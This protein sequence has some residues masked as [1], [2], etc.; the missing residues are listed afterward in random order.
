MNIIS[1]KYDFSAKELF[2][3]EMIRKYFISDVLDIPVEQIHSVRLSNTFLWKRYRRQKQG[4]LDV[5]VELNDDTKINIELQ[6][7]PYAHW[8]KRILFY[9]SK[10]FTEDL[11]VGDNYSR[12]NRCVS[13]SILDFNLKEGEKYNTIYRLRYEAHLKEI[14]GRNAREDYVREE[15]RKEGVGSM[16]RLTEILLNESR[17]DNLKRASTDKKYRQRLFEEYRIK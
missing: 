5:L 1:P 12:L 8:V 16:T 6:V 10:I 4:I 7:V 17:Y 14:R 9:L 2:S 13:I 15:G 11:K 3:I